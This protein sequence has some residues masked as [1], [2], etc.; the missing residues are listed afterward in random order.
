MP[1]LGPILNINISGGTGGSGGRGEVTGGSGGLGKAPRVKFTQQSFYVN[2]AA[3]LKDLKYVSARYNAAETT[4]QR[5]MKGTRVEVIQDIIHQ[6]TRPPDPLLRVVMCSGPAGSGKSTIA[7]TIAEDL[8]KKEKLLAAS[9]FFSRDYAERKE[10]KYLPSTLALQLADYDPGFENLLVTLLKSDRSRLLYADP[11]EQFQKMIVQLLA[12]MPLSRRP[13][14]ICLD[15]LDEC[16]KDHGRILLQWLS[17]TISDIPVHIRFFLTGR[18]EVKSNLGSL[19]ALCNTSDLAIDTETTRNDICLYVARSLTDPTWDESG[20]KVNDRDADE[21]TSR[22]AGLFIFA[23]TIVRFLKRSADHDVYP[24]TSVDILLNGNAPLD[25][26][27]VLYHQIVDEVI[28]EHTKRILGAIVDL[29]EPQDITSLAGL[30]KLNAQELRRTLVRLSAVLYV[31][32]DAG[33]IKILHLSFREFLSGREKQPGFLCGTETRQRSLALDTF[34]VMRTELKFNICHLPTSHVQN[35][36]IPDLEERKQKYIPG[37][38]AYSCR[39][40]ASHLASSHYSIEL[41]QIART[42]LE[43]YFLFWLEVLSLIGAVG[44]A[45]ETF[46]KFIQWS[47]EDPRM[48]ET[49]EFVRD[50]K[51]FI[52]LFRDPIIQS[53]PHIYL[54][55]LALA[56][57]Q[58]RIVNHFRPRFPLL[59]SAGIGRMEV[60]P[61]TMSVLEKH[62]DSVTSVAFSP[63][64]KQ[65]VSGSGDKTV[66]VWDAESGEVV[67][68]PFNGHTNRVTSVAFS[69]DGKRIVSGSYD[70]TVRVWDA[71]SG[72]VVAGPFNGHTNSVTSVA[73]SPDGKQIV[74]GSGDKTVRVWDAE[75]GEVVAGPFNGHTNRVTSVAFSPDGKRI[76]SGSDDKT[77][78]VWDAESGEVVAGPFNGHTNRVTSVAFSPDGKRIVSGS[79]DKTVRVWDAESGEVVAGP[80]NGHT[81]RVTSVAFSPDG[82]RIVSGSGDKTV[83]VWDAESGEVV[84]GPSFNGHTN[85]VTSVAFSPD[86]KQIVSGSGD[87]T[88]RVWD[89][90]SGEVVAGPFNGHTDWVTSVAFSPDGKRI[91]SGSDDKTVRVWDAESGE[92]VAGPFNGHTNRVTSVA[93]SPDG[94]QIVSGSGDKTVRVWDA[95]SGEVVAGPF[96]G[97]TNRVTSVAFSPDGKRIV[98]GS[99][100]Q[101]V[102]VWDAE[103]GEVVAGPFNGHTESVTS[104]AFSPDGKRIVSGS[105]DETVRVWDAESG[106]VVAGPFNGH[107]NSVTSVAFSPDGKRIVSGS[108]DQTVRVWDAESGEVVA[109]PFNGHTDLVTS[110]AFSPDGKRIVSGSWGRTVRVWDAER[111]EVVRVWDVESGEVPT[112]PFKIVCRKNHSMRSWFQSLNT[113]PPVNLPLGW[114][115]NQGWLSCRQSELIVWLP[116]SHRRGLWSPHNALVI[117]KE[118]T[119]LNFDNFVHGTEWMQCYRG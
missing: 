85:S 57:Q 47:F 23:A 75:S 24:Q 114:N 26:L 7:K 51:R 60:W 70:K 105:Y 78:R 113:T 84:A 77:V 12:Q 49:V 16:G 44:S 31:P 39:F 93:F 96:N 15:A 67:A 83:R 34:R 28:G 10:I 40:W 52:A 65:I 103:S 18:P 46:P 99:R 87:K 104:V 72:E 9:F 55:A 82:K 25:P 79:Y 92:V 119:T 88:V 30:L 95:E 17:D 6:L 107:I 115:V 50:G 29:V 108:R 36:D 27:H 43:G 98:S 66:R 81:N 116:D 8:D 1:A 71:E 19:S 73:F 38:L 90:E 45:A 42:F 74:S 112:G 22:A 11:K 61:A 3:V 100:D 101:T 117:S 53:A 54:S 33:V 5:C 14:V 21:I 32:D 35:T 86:G 91:V 80:F 37:H 63:D 69:P 13:W 4:A 56:P 118:Q 76:V 106:E 109:G 89:A 94:K 97:H 20:W 111:G 41:A 68:G 58:S 2:P 110:V 102:R 48:A 62:T 59:L 64:G